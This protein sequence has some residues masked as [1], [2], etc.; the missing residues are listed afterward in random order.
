V[1]RLLMG[2]RSTIPQAAAVPFRTSAEGD[3]EVLLIRR[4]QG[5]AWGIPKGLIDPG[6]TAPEAAAIEALEEAGVEGELLQE[7]LGTFEYAK[8]GGTCR[9]EVFGLRVTRVHER[10]EE[11]RLRERR[12]F[13]VARAARAAKRPAV[14]AL[15]AR[16]IT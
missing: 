12:W 2:V 16:I 11:E 7:S 8:F 6:H 4:R 10:Y 3:L 1:D 13:P 14:G 15:I 5:G 9:V